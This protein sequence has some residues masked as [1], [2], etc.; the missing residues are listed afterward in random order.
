MKPPDPFYLAGEHVAIDLP[1]ARALFTTRRGGVSGGPYAT[2]NLGRW[3]ED[4]PVAVEHNRVALAGRVGGRLAYGRQVHGNTVTRVTSPP[5]E[6]VVPDEADGQATSLPGVAPMVLTADCLPVAV[7]GHGAA[8]MLHAGWRGLAGGVIAEG[9]RAV[10]RARLP[11]AAHGCDRTRG[12]PVLLRGGR[13][14]PRG[15]CRS[16]RR[17]APR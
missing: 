8:A 17:R 9:V 3:T 2:L 14:G 12:R 13:R 7:A 11:R 5:V 16:R 6:G 10:R 4:D 1:G 15:V